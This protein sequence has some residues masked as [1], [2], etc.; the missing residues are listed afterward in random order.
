MSLYPPFT[1]FYNWI[2]CN[3]SPGRPEAEVWE[4][5]VIVSSSSPSCLLGSPPPERGLGAEPFF[6]TSLI[7]NSNSVF[8]FVSK[9]CYHYYVKIASCLP[10]SLLPLLP[11]SPP[12]RFSITGSHSRAPSHAQP[13]RRPTDSMDDH[14]HPGC[15]QCLVQQS[16]DYQ[17][18]MFKLAKPGR[19]Q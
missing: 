17:S 2:I 3:V 6:V 13:G 5:E 11:S 16:V 12:V 7:M 8:W 9:L 15:A 1:L 18:P 4:E 10:Q 14:I 19:V